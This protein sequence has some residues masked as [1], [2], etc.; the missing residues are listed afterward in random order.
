M[1][2]PSELAWLDSL[3]VQTCR[4]KHA[5]MHPAPEMQG[6]TRGQPLVPEALREEE[7]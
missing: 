3:F 6:R 1:A 2:E 4:L 7:S 5:H